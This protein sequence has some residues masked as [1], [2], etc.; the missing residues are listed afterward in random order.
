MLGERSLLLKKSF[1]GLVEEKLRLRILAEV[2]PER[3]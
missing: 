3:H 2:E 1:N